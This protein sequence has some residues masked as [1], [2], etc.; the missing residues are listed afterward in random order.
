MR[1]PCRLFLCRAGSVRWSPSRACLQVQSKAGV[2][3]VE[4]LFLR[5]GSM[6]DR[7]V[8]GDA[9]SMVVSG[10]TLSHLGVP[11]TP[12]LVAH[13]PYP[14][15]QVHVEGLIARL[16]RPK[17]PLH[18]LFLKTTASL[19]PPLSVQPIATLP[20]SGMH[21]LHGLDLHHFPDTKLLCRQQGRNLAMEWLN[22]DEALA[23]PPNAPGT[24][25][26]DDV[27]EIKI[28]GLAAGEWLDLCCASRAA[29]VS[30]ADS[31]VWRNHP[32]GM[33]R[34]RSKLVCS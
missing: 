27:C 2:T 6:L 20:A 3:T 17:S 19:P 16:A 26:S 25:E 32:Q 11:C 10:P 28:L 4:D 30:R 1:L 34:S 14:L 8:F 18:A 13:S 33:L 7:D 12:L 24:S 29:A 9:E 23:R 31:Q 15:L 21:T 5:L 22:R